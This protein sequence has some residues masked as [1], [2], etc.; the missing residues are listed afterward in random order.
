[1]FAEVIRKG[2]LAMFMIF[3]SNSGSSN[4]KVQVGI[5]IHVRYQYEVKTCFAVFV[6][7]I[8]L[9]V[10]WNDEEVFPV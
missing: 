9:L 8:C 3:V 1:M 4:F 10:T 5:F 7:F 6:L 2:S